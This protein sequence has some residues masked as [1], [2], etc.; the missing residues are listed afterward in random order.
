MLRSIPAS[1][2][3]QGP[4]DNVCGAAPGSRQSLHQH[5]P[6]PISSKP[7]FLKGIFTFRKAF[8]IAFK[9]CSTFSI[10]G[11]SWLQTSRTSLR[12]IRNRAAGGCSKSPTEAQHK[13]SDLS[14]RSQW[15]R[16]SPHCHHTV[17]VGCC[18]PGDTR[19]GTARA[20]VAG[21]NEAWSPPPL[22]LQN[23]LCLSR[24]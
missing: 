4:L 12:W 22:Q 1:P 10:C 18:L 20:R 16:L 23:A 9:E 13:G 7:M 6:A 15:S 3:R 2:V 8:Q 17:T 24:L 19:V 14:P 11:L 5:H 21:H